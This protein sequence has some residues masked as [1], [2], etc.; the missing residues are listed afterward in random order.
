MLKYTYVACIKRALDCILATIALLV[1]SPLMLLLWIAVRW[2]FGG[3]AIFTH[4]R[5]GQ[6]QKP[7]KFYKFR[8]MI[9]DPNLTDEERITPFGAVL[10]KSSL[11]EL[12]QLINVIKGEM[13][14]VGPRPLLPEYDSHYTKEQLKRF[15]VLPG[16]TGWAQVNGRNQIEWSQKLAYDVYYANHV[17]L[18]L[19]LIILL[20]TVGV[21]LRAAGFNRAGEAKRFDEQ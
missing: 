3:R 11:D 19:D 16:I 5:S 6:H 1:L 14:L 18:H 4:E 15:D 20:K 2:A 9:D 8:S 7:F 21:V 13:S 10:R 12:P 17:S